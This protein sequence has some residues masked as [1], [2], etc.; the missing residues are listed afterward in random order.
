MFYDYDV[1]EER[2]FLGK[3]SLAFR[4]QKICQPKIRR[5]ICV[6][7]CTWWRS[8]KKFHWL[9]YGIDVRCHF[10][11]HAC[12]K[13]NEGTPY[14]ISKHKIY[15]FKSKVT[16]LSDD[17]C[18]RSSRH[19]L[20]GIADASI[21]RQDFSWHKGT[22]FKNDVEKK[23]R[24]IMW[25]GLIELWVLRGSCRER[26]LRNAAETKSADSCQKPLSYRRAATELLNNAKNASNRIEVDEIC[27]RNV[28]LWGFI[29]R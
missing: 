11:F 24:W 20:D 27:E 3:I 15:G 2:W 14:Y 1:Y 22:L 9:S 26:L 29:S 5:L 23:V 4:P 17:L 18:L 16:I 7:S 12:G 10:C 13:R 28:N 21:M 25:W 19:W 6:K 8:S